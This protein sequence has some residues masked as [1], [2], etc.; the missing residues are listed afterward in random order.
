MKNGKY[1]SLAQYQDIKIGYGTV[2]S[3]NFKTIYIKLKTWIKPLENNNYDYIISK[4]TKKIKTH[5]FHNS[6]EIFCKESIVDINIKTSSLKL[7]KKSFMDLEITLFVKNN[8]DFRDKKMIKVVRNLIKDIIDNDFDN[9]N[10]Y[11]FHQNK[12]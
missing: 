1:S 9:K 4:T 11:N 7:N 8:I 10:F 12:N 5:I 3:I 6:N 2:D